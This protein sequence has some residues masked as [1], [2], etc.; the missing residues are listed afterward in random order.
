[1]SN[2]SKKQMEVCNIK[3][4]PAV[5]HAMDPAMSQTSTDQPWLEIFAAAVHNFHTGTPRGYAMLNS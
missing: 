1:M 2:N 4:R 3:I 5:T